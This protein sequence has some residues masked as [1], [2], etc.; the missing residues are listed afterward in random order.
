MTTDRVQPG[1][2]GNVNALRLLAALL[3]LWGDGE[4]LSGVTTPTFWG[5]PLVS[6]GFA[7]FF[8]TSGFLLAGS[9]EARPE[10]CA[11]AARRARRTWP[12]LA[13]CTLLTAFVLGPLVS[14]RTFNLYLHDKAVW[15]YL[16]NLVLFHHRYLPGVFAHARLVGVVDG[17]LWT[18][19]PGM[20][21][22]ATVPLFGRLADAPRAIAFAV[23][24]AA[25]GS[26]AFLVPIGPAGHGPIVWGADSVAVLQ[27]VP[28]F[29]VGAFWHDVARRRPDIMRGDVALLAVLATW[30]IAAWFGAWSAPLR[31]A[32]LPYTVALFARGSMSGLRVAGWFGDLSYGIYLWSFPIQ[33]V[34]LTRTEV[35]QPVLLC[36]A[37]TLPVA[38]LS[39]HLVECPAIGRDGS[40]HLTTFR[41]KR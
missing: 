30:G 21:C 8:A 39:R 28:F 5:L 22:A 35:D 7:L 9:W 12:G 31:W 11:Y 19:F 20:L 13:A 26:C 34:I 23:A 32:V 29:F 18:L 17:T 41:K 24:A 6:V 16:G 40:L 10:L 4:T 33:Q 37:V 1:R 3:V 36:L 25:C 38:F 2:H 14:S 15:H 27:V